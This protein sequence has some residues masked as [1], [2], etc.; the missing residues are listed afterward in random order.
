MPTLPSVFYSFNIHYSELTIQRSGSPRFG[1]VK[2]APAWIQKY[3]I[4]WAYR[5]CKEPRRLFKRYFT[6]NSL[7]LYYSLRDRVVS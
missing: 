6:Y 7:F 3:G 4:E 5:L 2:Q 1:D